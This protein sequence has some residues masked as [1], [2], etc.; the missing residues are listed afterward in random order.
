MDGEEKRAI[1]TEQSGVV[2][3]LVGAQ[4]PLVIKKLEVVSS[5][6]TWQLSS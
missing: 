3:L 5:L 6:M 2:M 4:H 1:S